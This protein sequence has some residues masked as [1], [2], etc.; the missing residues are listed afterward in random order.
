VP[1]PSEDGTLY[2]EFVAPAIGE[3]FRC[4]WYEGVLVQFDTLALNVG[5]FGAA[6]HTVVEVPTPT[7]VAVTFGEMP[8]FTVMLFDVPLHEPHVATSV[9]TW[10]PTPRPSGT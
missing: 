10:L 7:I 6:E 1:T 5:K 2:V 4:H 9:N 8:T 3:P